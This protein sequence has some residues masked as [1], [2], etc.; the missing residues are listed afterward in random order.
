[1]TGS[2]T[3]IS[4]NTAMHIIF[5]HLSFFICT[6]S[7]LFGCTTYRADIPSR[8]HFIVCRFIHP[9]LLRHRIMVNTSGLDL[10]A[11]ESGIVYRFVFLCICRYI[12]SAGIT[13]NMVFVNRLL[14]CLLHRLGLIMPGCLMMNLFCLCYPLMGMLICF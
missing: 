12:C 6:S 1:M 9:H 5:F 14:V 10:P 11:A 3:I 4:A 7:S 13:K 2:S 8:H